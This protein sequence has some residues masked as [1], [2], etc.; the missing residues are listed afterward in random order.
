MSAYTFMKPIIYILK[1]ANNYRLSDFTLDC[2][3][4]V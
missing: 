3:D 1:F 4:S 2:A